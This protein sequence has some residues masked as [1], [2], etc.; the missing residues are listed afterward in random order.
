MQS[1]RVR[2]AKEGCA[3]AAPMLACLDGERKLLLRLALMITGNAEG[4]RQSFIKARDVALQAWYP[5]RERSTEYC[6][7]L[8]IEAALS[9]SYDAICSCRPDYAN[10]E[11]TH[12]EHLVQTS[13]SKLEKYHTFL[14]RID[15]SIIIA[16]LDALSR[17]VLILRITARVSILDCTQRL[18]L[19]PDTILAANCRAMSW[20]G[21]MQRRVPKDFV[22]K[23]LAEVCT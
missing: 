20:V 21:H 12:P 16:S 17:A 9:T 19:P 10:L 8:T 23:D 5:L 15:P 6:K 11:C 4:A 2:E 3:P 18:E 22:T 7:W 1:T 14:F 13:D